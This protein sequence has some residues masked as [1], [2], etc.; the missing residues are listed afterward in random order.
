MIESGFFYSI[1]GDRK[2]NADKINSGLSGF[3]SETGVY[4]KVG[5]GFRVIACEGMTIAVVTGRARICER[6]VTNIST[7][8]LTLEAAD[9]MLNRYDA[10]VLCLGYEEREIRLEV[11]KGANATNPVKPEP[12]RS[13]EKYEIVLAYVYVAAGATK[14]SE[15]QIQDTRADEAVCG[16]A[17]LLVDG[18]KVGIKKL[19]NVILL[20]ENTDS[21]NAGISDIDIENDSIIVDVNGIMLKEG[22]EYEITG[23]GSKTIINFKNTMDPFNEIGITVIKPVIEVSEE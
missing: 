14:I 7:E 1:E 6:F 11:K 5:G 3:L 21:I 17:K 2:Y 12:E 23:T 13:M 15:Q 16:F 18:V 20:E 9:I 8:H 22:R 19:E 10:V 4:K